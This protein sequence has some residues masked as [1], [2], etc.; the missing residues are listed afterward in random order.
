MHSDQDVAPETEV[1]P[2]I[3][4]TLEPAIDELLVECERA[5]ASGRHLDGVGQAEAVLARPGATK[6]QQAQ[7]RELLA[8]HRLRLGDY[9]A[10]V[11]QGLLALE[12]LDGSGDLIRQSKVHC[13]L[14]LA[15]SDT[16]LYEQA[17]RHVLV[18]LETARTSGSAVAEFWALSRSSMVHEGMGDSEQALV[19][20]QQA[21][22]MSRTID[23]AEA[24]FV[25]LNNLGDTCL[26]QAQAQRAHGLDAGP[27]LKRALLLVR[28]AVA[29]APGQGHSFYESIA[30]PHL[31]S[32]LIALGEHA[33]AREQAGRARR[34][35]KTNGFRSLEE[36]NDAQLA[37]VARGEGRIDDA[38]AMMNAQLMVATLEDDPALHIMLHQSLYEMHKQTGRFEQALVHYEELHALIVKRT[39]DTAG[40]QSQ[41]LV[42]TLGI[43]QARH[44]AE[45]SQLDAERLRIRAAELDLQANTDPLTRLPNRRAL[46][47]QLPPLMGLARDHRQ[48]LC[49][50]MID[51]DHFKQVNDEHGHATGDQVLSA[52]AS[53]LRAVTRD[54]DMAVR[55]G[56]E[57]FL[58]V[59]ADTTLEQAEQACERLLASVRGYHWGALAPGL[60][61]TVS[62]GLAE[63]TPGETVAGWL[64]RAD[65]ALY[66]AKGGGRDQLA[67]AA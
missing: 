31:V 4:S 17:L 63:L 33:E 7:A 15:Y 58:L 57:E 65:A 23:D 46:D 40:I 35:A 36:N 47:R 44:E 59:F 66:D 12:F 67:I 27:S 5:S 21:L 3:D 61:C 20:G 9:E 43:E 45:R 11:E 49:V 16:G 42:N 50:A 24:R 32:I 6:R 18:A 28:E 37:E 34:L 64:A 22:E 55:V 26:V 41:M 25:G 2:A 30:R 29:V 10:S 1:K 54:S 53:L 39:T 60:A 51:M 56:G 13:T 52:M 48:P 14:V 38:T 19:L 8:L 62:V